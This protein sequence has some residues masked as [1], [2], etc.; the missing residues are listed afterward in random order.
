MTFTVTYRA[1]DGA[2]AEVE[3]EAASRAACV[4]ACKA[5]GVAPLGIREGRASSR[6]RAA[7]TA[8]PH[9]GRAEAR[10]SPRRGLYLAVAVLCAAAVGGGL[11]WW[12][13]RTD[14]PPAEKPKDAKPAAAKS[15]PQ[16][17]PVP[18]KPAAQAPA[19]ASAASLAF[20]GSVR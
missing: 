17:R 6:P 18:K 7:E 2:K 11:W 20:P 15:V 10:P 1:K 12:L 4:A 5:R 19:A 3:I 13:G 9:D 14:A 16:P 8:V